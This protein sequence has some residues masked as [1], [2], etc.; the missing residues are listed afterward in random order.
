[1]ASRGRGRSSFREKGGKGFGS[2]RYVLDEDDD[3]DYRHRSRS[4]ARGAQRS[5]ASQ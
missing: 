3:R 4:H 2:N 1:M 5:E